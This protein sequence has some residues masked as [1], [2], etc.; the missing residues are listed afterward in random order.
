MNLKKPTIKLT[1][2]ILKKLLQH[3]KHIAQR[4]SFHLRGYIGL[5]IGISVFFLSSCYTAKQHRLLRKLDSSLSR[6][7]IDSAQIG[8]LT[9]RTDS[10]SKADTINIAKGAEMNNQLSTLKNQT[11]TLHQSI[12]KQKEKVIRKTILKKEYLQ[13]YPKVNNL[14]DEVVLKA[15][16]RDTLFRKIERQFE[17]P[18]YEGEKGR[19]SKMLKS[20]AKQTEKDAAKVNT[21][22]N[23]KDSLIISGSVDTSTS[24]IVDKRL[25]N[26][27]KKF[28]SISVEIKFLG[29]QLNS[30]TEFK[31][32]FALIK[33]KILLV[34][35][36]V[37]KKAASREYVMN[38]ILESISTPKPSLFNLAAFFGPGGYKIPGE[39]KK[40]AIQYFSPIID[41]LT[42]FSNKYQAVYRTARI[43]Q[44]IFLWGLH[45]TKC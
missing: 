9:R 43:M 37:N 44:Q 28:D 41:S 4:L 26:F 39:K 33:T 14:Y 24:A 25:A 45:Y 21:I 10:L 1:F 36:V 20:A 19:L 29:Q 7:I 12:L 13:I 11:D 31:N 16:I 40:L 22:G 17:E 5:C 35:S 15:H 8:Y 30:A 34:D 27:K 42:K 23:A 6:Q 3:N 38:M 2:A 32:N 18:N